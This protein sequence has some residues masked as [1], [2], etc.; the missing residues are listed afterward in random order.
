MFYMSS[1]RI[2]AAK[3]MELDQ[4]LKKYRKSFKRILAYSSTNSISHLV[5]T[6]K[7]LDLKNFAQ[8]Q[9]ITNLNN[10]VEYI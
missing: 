10:E 4:I 7:A 2:G 8:F 9:Y 1:V 6:Y 5:D 3:E